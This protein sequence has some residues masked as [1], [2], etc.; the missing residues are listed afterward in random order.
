MRISWRRVSL[1]FPG[2]LLA[3]S[4]NASSSNES[5]STS[6]SSSGCGVSD[7][8]TASSAGVRD[9]PSSRGGQFGAPS[10]PAP[11]GQSWKPIET[12][13]CGRGG[14]S[15]VL[16]DE[17]CGDGEGN[18]DPETMHAPMFRDGAVSGGHL[19]AI[20]ATH[21]WSFD[22]AQPTESARKSLVTGLG[23]PLAVAQRGSELVL[24][25]GKSGLVMVDVTNPADPRRSRSIELSGGAFDVQVNGDKAIVALGR[26][27]IAEVN[28][29]PATPWITRAWPLWG[30]A[31]GVQARGN[32]AYV[33]AC[34]SFK[35][36]DLATGNVVGETW[37]PNAYV[38]GRLVA[39][40]KKVTL[41]DDVA[42][43][44]AGRYGAVAIDISTPQQPKV[45]GNC[46]VTDDPS[47]YAS[48]VRAS[49]DKLFVAGGEWGILPVGIASSKSA[50]SKLQVLPPKPPS[51]DEP[52]STKPPWEVVP[53]ETLWAPPPPRKDP[54]QTLPVGDRV[55]AFGDARRI[56][57][58]AVDV[59]NALDPALP[60]MS[61][62][63]EPRSLL[64]VTA[65]ATRVVTVGPRGGVFTIGTNGKLTRATSNA[66]ASLRE[67]TAV[68]T[69]PGGRFVA[70][71]PDGL[72]VEGSSTPIAVPDAS[73]LAAMDADH[74]AV[75][76][77]G[78]V[79][80]VDVSSGAR[81][82]Y[83]VGWANLPASLTADASAVYYAGPEWPKTIELSGGKTTF[84][85]PHTVFDE[86]EILDPVRWRQRLPRRHLLATGRGLVEIA[87]VGSVVGLALHSNGGVKKVSLPPTTYA[88]AASDGKHVYAVG[89][90]RGL[91]RSTLVSIDITGEAPVVVGIESFT[92]AASG[93]ATAAGRVFVSDADG[94]IRAYGIDA[95][96]SAVLGATTEVAK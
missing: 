29:A 95:D 94:A 2:V 32:Y 71:G 44:A 93:V 52:C 11:T 22:L 34:G 65:S 64:G 56:G 91:Y 60:I 69:L 61:R 90:D 31:A 76:V 13:T 35:V 47:F 43:V 12:E 50:C 66:E 37:V 75:T 8:D 88:A 92:G 27:G 48:G 4:F 59:R 7:S 68:T 45:L 26:G 84:L 46:T 41:V 9:A 80:I 63:D 96:G 79:Q 89:L 77:K 25:S 72:T 38:D 51:Q 5:R 85:D 49:A 17:V 20:D 81:T 62:F 67:S 3:C 86:T 21:L 1:F 54:V 33:A 73:A 40:A 83:S 53:W 70:L 57:V 87:G 78:G 16:V 55:Y 82:S 14:I 42:F 28:L 24:A 23:T 18:D 10:E 39:P 15:W 19:F 30:F 36:V 58:R 74:V 6:S